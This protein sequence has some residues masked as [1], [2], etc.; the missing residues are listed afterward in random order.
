M[1]QMKVL[2]PHTQVKTA[3]GVGNGTHCHL[4]GC[5]ASQFAIRRKAQPHQ[6][7]SALRLPVL[8]DPHLD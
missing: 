6:E 2:N 8:L 1:T 4:M 3:S 5:L 7:A